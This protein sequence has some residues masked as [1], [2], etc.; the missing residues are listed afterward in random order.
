[1]KLIKLAFLS[2]MMTPTY[3]FWMSRLCGHWEMLLVIP[4]DVV[5]LS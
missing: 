3:I 5:T 4:L 2:K 1:M